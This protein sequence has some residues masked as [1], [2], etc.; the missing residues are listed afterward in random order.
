MKD[1]KLYING[2]WAGT[3]AVRDVLRTYDQ[4][5]IGR[6]H[7]GGP[8]EM[9]R[10]IAAAAGATAAMKALTSAQKYDILTAITAGVTKRREEFARGISDEAGKPIRDSRVEVDRAILGFTLSAEE[11]RRQYGEVLPL[12]LT[13]ASAGRI[14]ITRRFPIGPVGAITPFNFPLNLGVHK[15]GPAIAAGNPLV[16]KP[17]EKTPLTALRLAEIIHETAL[18]RG[19]FN[20]VVAREPA[21]GEMLATDDRIRMLSFTGAAP[22]G[23]RLKGLANRKRVTLELGG[24][25]AVIVH[26]DAD[27]GLAVSRCVV[28][29]FGY[30]GQICISVQRIYVHRPM[31]DEFVPHLVEAARALAVGD[32]ADEATTFVPMIAEQAAIAA[33]ERVRAALSEGAK[34]LL[35][36]ERAG[37]AFGP[38]ILTDT[39]P[40]MAVSREEVFAPIVLVEPY[41]DFSA[42]LDRVN[43]GPFGLQAGV[44]TRDVGRLFQAFS[45]L[46]VGGVIGNDIPTFRAD[47]MPYGGEK[48]SG[49]GR[50]GIRYAIEEM[51]ELRILA[52]AL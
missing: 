44:F 45:T 16:L 12:D 10:A 43:E 52:L 30:A 47:N 14:G 13:A 42:A 39:A 33:E 50:E 19:A 40:D 25:A 34:A 49:F 38:T 8:A 48:D 15:I 2:E 5:P 18:P 51:T 46:E 31:W 4:T 35:L 1:W 3:D 28:G 24:N 6:V 7:M 21:L 29:A 9:D 32:P 17:A 22:V 11:A 36:G 26:S 41:D 27:L 23:W 20:V 37:A